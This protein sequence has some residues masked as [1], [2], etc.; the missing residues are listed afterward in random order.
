MYILLFGRQTLRNLIYNVSS[1][2]PYF[3]WKAFTYLTYTNNTG[4]NV[5]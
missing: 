3:F 2:Q 1:L 4:A 5:P